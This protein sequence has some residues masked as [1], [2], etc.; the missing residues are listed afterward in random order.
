MRNATTFESWQR[1]SGPSATRESDEV[2][3]LL[4]LA[5]ISINGPRTWDIQVH[6]ENSFR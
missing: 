6:E 5:G 2:Q 4:A 3:R 1:H